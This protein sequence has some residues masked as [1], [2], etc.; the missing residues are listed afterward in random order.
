[1][2]VIDETHDPKLRTWVP[3]ANEALDFPIQNLPLAAFLYEGQPHIGVGI[4][5]FVLDLSTWL[6]GVDLAPFFKLSASDRKLLRYSVSRALREGS[7]ERLLY[8]Q[9]DCHFLLPCQIGDYTD[10]YASIDHARNVGALFRPDNPLHPNYRYMPIGYHGRASSIVVSGSEIRRPWGQLGKEHCGATEELDYEIELGAFIGPGNDIGKRIQIGEAGDHLA[11]ICLLNDWS[12]R[13]IQRWESQPLGPFQSKSFATSISRWIVT[14]DALAPFFV[15][16]PQQHRVEP[17][18]LR[19]NAGALDIQVEAHLHTHE[20]RHGERISHANFSQMYWTF[21][22]LITHHTANGCPLRPGDL[23]GSGTISG[24]EKE[25]RGCL[26]EL[27]K[28]GREPLHLADG[29]QRSFLLDGDTVTLQ[30]SCHRDGFRQIGFGD[31]LGTIVP[32]FQ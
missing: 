31:C 22:Q 32:A 27:T 10:F 12:A 19:T 24:P 29:I 9:S 2:A 1:M 5:D 18:Y 20:A 8:E 23:L 30:A 6:E 3:G 16:A 21:S 28:L 15:R 7:P 13:D 11:G 14:V 17:E 25:N 4:G 26:L